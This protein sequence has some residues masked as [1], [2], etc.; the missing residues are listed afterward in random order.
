ML[1]EGAKEGQAKLDGGAEGF[2]QGKVYVGEIK[3]NQRTFGFIKS[4]NLPNEMHGGLRSIRSI[5]RTIDWFDRF[6]R[7]HIR[8]NAKT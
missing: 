3:S 6:D 5:G 1:D 2:V 4:P 8:K 7:F